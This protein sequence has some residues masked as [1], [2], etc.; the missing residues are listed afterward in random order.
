MIRV[1]DLLS[2]VEEINDP[3]VLTEMHRMCTFVVQIIHILRETP[4]EQA[5]PLLGE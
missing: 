1:D 5:T 3:N 4:S 2:T